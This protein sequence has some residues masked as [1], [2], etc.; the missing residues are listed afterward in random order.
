MRM[1]FSA[2]LAVIAVVL[3]TPPVGARTLKIATLS[4][5]GHTWM[6]EMRQGADEIRARTDGRVKLKA[7]PAN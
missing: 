5:E 1:N 2:F 3:A 6:R 7:Q 4:P